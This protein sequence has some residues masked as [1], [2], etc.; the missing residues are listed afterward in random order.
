MTLTIIAAPKGVLA[1]YG[2]SALIL[3]LSMDWEWAFYILVISMLPLIVLLCLTDKSL[4]NIQ[5]HLKT[6]SVPAV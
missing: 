2:I 6:L 1:G 5:E 3:T 4:I